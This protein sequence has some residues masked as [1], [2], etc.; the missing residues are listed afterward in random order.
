VAL[1]VPPPASITVHDTAVFAVPVTVA[2]N[3]CV[4]P[5]V[6]L[7]VVGAMVTR[8]AGFTVTVA[9]LDFDVSATLVALT[10]YVPVV[11]GAV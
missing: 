9:W 2:V 8:T 1:T 3:C 11:A 4:E 5:I 6:K 7:T 10:W